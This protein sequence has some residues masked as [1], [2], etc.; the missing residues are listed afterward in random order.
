M[1]TVNISLNTRSID[2][3]LRELDAFEKWLHTRTKAFVKAL[4][5]IGVQVATV[6]FQTA[7]YA[8]SNDVRC[9]IREL[10]D[11]H[12]AVVATGSATLFIEFGT[13]VVYIGGLHPEA[14]ELGMIRGEYGKGRGNNIHGWYYKGDPGSGGYGTVRRAGTPTE[15]VHT[16]GNPANMCMYNT[17]EELERKFEEVARKVFV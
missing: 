6:R 1:K 5:K 8:G 3:A 13:G 2:R 15:V 14:S 7:G 9:S 11:H 12:L 16:L 4:G 17:V 10:D